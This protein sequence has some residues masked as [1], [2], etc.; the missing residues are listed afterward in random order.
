M[1]SAVSRVLVAV[2]VVAA[3]GST[4]ACGGSGDDDGKQAAKPGA[5]K[6]ANDP[7]DG[8]GSGAA[9]KL[10]KA[11]LASGDVKGYK[12]E[13]ADKATPRPAGATSPA[14]CAPLAAV[15]G[16]GTP[17]KADAHAGRYLSSSS[18]EDATGVDVGLSA[19]KPDGA[20]KVM[21]DL[22]AALKSKKCA[23]FGVGGDR[24]IGVRAVTAPGKGD[25][26]VSYKLAH[27]EG[28][29]MMREGVTVVRSGGTL[30]VFKASNLYDPE[31]VQ[32]DREAERNG[33]KGAGAPTADEDP[34]VAPAI[35]D[36]QVAKL[37]QL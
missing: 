20:E 18:D 32:D 33:M 25:E 4:A 11:A 34:K 30:M 23:T 5:S 9:A 12:V 27:R 21:D 2:S 31:S 26:T 35:V 14:G 22:N 8:G 13:K 10:E 17:P 19:Y 1:K 28:K 3:L 7:K 24:Y 37:R 29:F 6:G 16:P 36:A 15:L